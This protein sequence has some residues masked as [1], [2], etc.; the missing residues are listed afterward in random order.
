MRA[1]SNLRA[2]AYGIAL[3]GVAP[4]ACTHR[5][6]GESTQELL[7]RAIQP[8]IDGAASGARHDHVVIL[9]RFED[10]GRKSLCT[11]TLVADSLV[12]TARH[13]VSATDASAMCGQDGAPVVG[14][15]LHGDRAAA[16]FAV[17]VGAAGVAPP[18]T[19]QGQASARGKALVVDDARTICN[20]DVAFVVLDRAL[21][22]PIAQLRMGPPATGETFTAV[23]WGI[24]QTGSLPATRTERAGLSV[25]L[26]G[27][28]AFPEDARYGVGSAEL[29]VGES[30]CSGDSGSPVLASSGAVVGVAS[31]AGNG[32]PRDPSNYASVCMGETVHAVYTHLGAFQALVTR[33]FAAAGATPWLEGAGDPR[34]AKVDAAPPD[35]R[36]STPSATPETAVM[37]APTPP[38]PE[39]EPAPGPGAAAGACTLGGAPSEDPVAFAIGATALLATVGRLLRRRRPA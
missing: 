31:R 12:L 24:D 3:L 2:C 25:V 13:C 36:G 22:A 27:P 15:V 7:G 39:P 38:E 1:A 8:I 9:A 26:A 33:A 19:D 30:A 17:F 21:A 35:G 4:P 18:S 37:A 14:G 6:E 16:D 29:L 23:G 10:G 11:G 32:K 34:A 20:H 5:I 28:T